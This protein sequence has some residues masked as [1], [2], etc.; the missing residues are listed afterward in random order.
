MRTLFNRKLILSSIF[1]IVPLCLLIISEYYFESVRQNNTSFHTFTFSK[2]KDEN[3]DKQ[4]SNIPN[5]AVIERVFITGFF[6]DWSTNNP[7]FELQANGPDSWRKSF[8]LPPGDIQYKFIVF[9]AG[10]DS[11]IWIEDPTNSNQVSDSHGGVNSVV[12]IPDYAF[13]ELVVQIVLLVTIVFVFTYLCLLKLLSWLINRK[14][15]ISQKIVFVTMLILF[16]TN[17]FM[18]FYQVYESRN[19]VKQGIIDSVHTLHLSLVSDGVEFSVLE[20]QKET[21][22]NSLKDLLWQAITRV[23][24]AQRSVFQITISDV[25][26]FD[27]QLQLVH[28]QNRE[29]NNGLQALR[30]ETAGFSNERDYYLEGVFQPLLEEAKLHK[31]MYGISVSHPGEKIKAI[32]TF[33]TRW[34]RVALGFSNLMLPI[35]DKGQLQGYYAVAIQVKL[36]G[37]EIQRIVLLN[38]ML[39]SLILL[40]SLLLLRSVGR[41]MTANLDKLIQ[42]SKRINQGDLDTQ[43]KVET[44]DEIQ[45]LAEHFA[46]MQKSLKHSF[47][48]IEEQNTKL[49]KA[50]YFDL[51]TGLPNRRKLIQDLSYFKTG[52]LVL[53]ELKE[54][55]QMQDFLGDTIA[56]ELINSVVTRLQQAIDS[57]IQ[58]SLYR[59][60]PNQLCLAL[61]GIAN[62]VT[63][64]TVASNINE[65][66]ENQPFQIAQISLRLSCVSGLCSAE[67]FFE[68]AEVQYDRVQLA[69]Q[70][71]KQT[72]QKIAFYQPSMDKGSTLERNLEIIQTIRDAIR[73]N[74][75]LPFFQPIVS[76]HDCQVV[77]YECLVRI[78]QEPGIILAPNS[79]LPAA[80]QSGLYQ[81]ISHIM[82][83]KCLAVA[84]KLDTAITLNLSA[85][86]T[87]NSQSRSHILALLRE[88]RDIT[89]KVTLEITE[90]DQIDDYEQMKS[91][92]DEVKELGCRIAL[93]DFGAGYSNFT[94]LLSLNID[95]IKIDGSLI[96]NI[97]TETNAMKISQAIV[98]C[99]RSLGIQTV[100]EY[101]HSEKIYQITKQLGVDFCQGYYFGAPQEKLSD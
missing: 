75:I 58:A 93:D 5:N 53:F 10:Q 40:M 80:K 90:T 26:V 92:V 37:Q 12:S 88:H 38:L 94:H 66:I 51:Q 100:A 50:A 30:A 62:N 4:I 13:Y 41:V 96:K 84:K 36:F 78:K 8:Q 14:M 68:L 49:N 98:E 21:L 70:I 86:D 42:W 39:V 24:K 73:D 89:D 11:P 35:E 28:V 60:A 44:Q 85:Q 18:V 97:D 31:N 87:E 7:F 81:S 55:M 56:T 2:S 27:E 29:Q 69:L 15:P 64:K 25:A 48:K 61:S 47:D 45:T 63:L 20:N 74:R 82:F 59:V 34:A 54:Y 9:I 72:Q 16:T 52:S 95:Y 83:D 77:A 43:V 19:L 33:E 17:G 46:E 32:E 91:F 76:A 57:T 6:S 23:E 1:L 65:S 3:S 71:A 67:H 79:F 99:A 22:G 101:V